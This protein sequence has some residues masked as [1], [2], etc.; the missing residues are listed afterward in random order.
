MAAGRQWIPVSHGPK[1][2]FCGCPQ[3][4]ESTFPNHLSA[5]SEKIQ[6][7][8][9]F[10]GGNFFEEIRNKEMKRKRRGKNLLRFRRNYPLGISLH[11]VFQIVEADDRRLRAFQQMKLKTRHSLRQSGICGKV[12]WNRTT[13]GELL[14]F[15]FRLEEEGPVEMF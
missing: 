10:P 9:T 6:R 4:I 14:P 1:L 2:D 12:G 13:P 15:L 8:K 5:Q 7:G 11:P 3:R